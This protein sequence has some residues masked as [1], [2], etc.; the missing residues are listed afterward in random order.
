MAVFSPCDS[1]IS[2]TWPCNARFPKS[3]NYICCFVPEA[4]CVK[5]CEISIRI[6]LVFL[7]PGMLWDL[8]AAAADILVFR[9]TVSSLVP[10][11][12]FIVKKSSAIPSIALHRAR[13]TY[14]GNSQQKIETGNWRRDNGA[15]S[16]NVL[17][18]VCMQQAM[19]HMTILPYYEILLKLLK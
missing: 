12:Y 1:L 6:D 14:G 13:S 16:T 18:W 7:W 17:T 3:G 4:S 15:R 10:T 9:K 5:P 11:L 19:H 2:R 8:L